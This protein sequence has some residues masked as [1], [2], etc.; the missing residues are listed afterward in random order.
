MANMMKL[1]VFFP[2]EWKFTSNCLSRYMND[3]VLSSLDSAPN[4][5]RITDP[6]FLSSYNLLI[7]IFCITYPH[8]PTNRQPDTSYLVIDIVEILVGKPNFVVLEVERDI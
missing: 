5:L 1:Y 7:D 2:V 4:S 6:S 3:A 8:A